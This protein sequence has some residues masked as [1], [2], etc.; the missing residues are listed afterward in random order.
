MNIHE[1]RKAEQRCWKT[2]W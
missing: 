2:D 1:W